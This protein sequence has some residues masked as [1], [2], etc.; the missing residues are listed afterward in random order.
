MKIL[1]SDFDNTIYFPDN[2]ELT[3]DNIESI[4]KFITKGNI[5]CVITGRNYTDLKVYLNKYNIPYSYL[6][7]E[8]GAKIFNNMDYCID[9]TYLDE[10]MI[11]EIKSI[12]DEIKC[13]YYLDDGYNKTEYLKD[14]VKIV[15]NCKN[16]KEK[17]RIVKII[18]E[19]VDVHIYASRTHVNIINKIVN[20]KYALNKLIELEDLKA[21][22]YVIGDNDNDYEMLESFSGGVIKKHHKVLDGLNKKEYNTLGDYIEE[23]MKN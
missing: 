20:K 22:I 14:V 17:D 18:K 21:K 8:D 4:K 16:Q 10:E 5:F 2:D 7:C 23:L 13:D 11:D 3:K 15:V 6:I 12:L 9:T 19:K 1:A